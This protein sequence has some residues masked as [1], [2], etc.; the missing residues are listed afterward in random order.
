MSPPDNPV[1]ERT[2]AASEAS[3][4]FRLRNVT[5]RFSGATAVENVDFDLHPGEVHA[6]VGENGADHMMPDSPTV[7]QAALVRRGFLYGRWRRPEHRSKN[8]GRVPA[9]LRSLN[10]IYAGSLHR[11]LTMELGVLR[12]RFRKVL[13]AEPT[14]IGG[15]SA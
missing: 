5:K 12:A 9:P 10:E 7:P 3:A 1:T 15:D 2:A 4:V 8:H 14:L 6:L 13:K 11:S